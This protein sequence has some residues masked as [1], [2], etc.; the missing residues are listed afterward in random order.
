VEPGVRDALDDYGARRR[1]GD[2]LCTIAARDPYA[3]EPNVPRFGVLTAGSGG[4]RATLEDPLG[5]LA[6]GYLKTGRGPTW[7][8]LDWLAAR[9]RACLGYVP[10]DPS[11]GVPEAPRA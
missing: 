2:G 11:A 5:V 1:E 3:R 9:G 8:A 7:H 10:G 4:A 6:S